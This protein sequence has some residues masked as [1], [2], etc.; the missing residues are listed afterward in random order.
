M[1]TVTPPYYFD[2]FL[3]PARRR[4]PTP[5]ERKLGLTLKDLDWLPT[6]YYATDA[7]RANSTVQGHPMRVERLLVN[8]P[9]QPAIPLAGAFMIS[10]TPDDAKAVLYTP[11]GGLE[12]F[13]SHAT[14]LKDVETRLARPAQRAEL[15]QFVS[16]AERGALPSTAPLTLSTAVILGAVMEDQEQSIL[17]GQQSNLAAMLNELRA[18]PSLREMLDTILGTMARADFP[19]LNQADTRVNTF[20]R[21]P[22]GGERQWVASEPLREVLLRFYVQQSWPVDQTH[23]FFNPAHDIRTFNRD[24]LAQ[25]QQRWNS[26]VE[27]TSASL[28]SLLKSL[29]RSYW[30]ADVTVG[31]SRRQFFAQAMRDK[32]RADLLFKHQQTIVSSDESQALRSLFLADQTARSVADKH[33]NVEKARIHAP[34][35]HYVDLAGT[36]M[37]SHT[38]A[39]L[40]TQSRG[41]QVL[42]NLNDLNATLLTMLKTAG[43]EDELLNFLSLDERNVF[44]GMDQIQI[45]GKPVV[46]DVFQEM[47]EDILAK[48]LDNLEYVLGQYRRSAGGV[49]LGALL[50]SALDVRNLLDSRLLERET[51]GR[52]S[53]HPVTRDNARPATVLAEK[54]RLHLQRLQTVEAAMAQDRNKYP[55]YAQ[56]SLPSLP[57]LLLDANRVHLGW[58]MLQGLTGEV[59]LRQLQKNLPPNALALLG[60]ALNSDGMSRLTRHGLNG[61]I[62]DAYS[63][64]LKVGANT[65]LQTVSNCFVLTER[66]GTDPV[67]SGAAVLWTPRYGYEAFA[68][69]KVLGETLAQR[70]KDPLARLAL[71]ENLPVTQRVPHQPY[72]L[73]PLQRIDGHLLENRQQSYG[74]VLRDEI[75]YLLSMRLRA[76]RFEQCMLSLIQRAPPTNLPRA[77]AIAR[78]LVHQQ[79]LPVWLGMAKPRQQILHA[80]LL[81][82]CRISA[83]D[84]RDYLHSVTPMRAQAVSSLSTLLN[85]RFPGQVVNPD[86]VMIPARI[87]LPG[88]TQSLTD[89]ALRHLPELRAEDVRPQSRTATPLPAALDGNAVVQLVRQLDLKSLYRKQLTPLLKGTAETVRERRQL[90]CRQLPW[91]LLRYAHEQ[92]LDNR[93]SAAGWSLVQQAFDMPDA[94]ARAAVSGA[95][96]IIRPLELI[97]TPG[98]ALVKA[99]GCYLIGSG[100]GPLILY[101]PYSPGH[102]LK[103]YATEAALLSEFT[104]PGALQ[105]WV[106]G[107]MQAPHQA[108]YRN[109]LGQSGDRGGSEFSLGSTPIAGNLLKQLFQDNGD[110]L[111]Q[112]LA[113]QFSKS[114][115]AQWDAVT[116]LLSQ[117]IPKSVQFLAGKLAYPLVVWR[118][119]KLFK[120]SAEDLQQ[121]RWQHAL[122]TFACGVAELA[123]LRNELDRVLPSTPAPQQDS[124][125]EHQLQAP[126]PTAQALAD[127]D[128]T[129]PERTQLQAFERHDI[130]MVDLAQIAQTGVYVDG[131]GTRHFVP[132]AGKVYPV[133]KAGEHWRLST[134]ELHGPYVQRDA[135]GAWTLDLG[136]HHPRYGQSLQGMAGRY[137]T[138]GHEREIINVEARGIRQIAALSSWKAQCINEGLN[139]ATYYAA[140]CKKNLTHFAIARD[141]NSR[142]GRFFS[143]FFGVVMLTADQVKRIERRIDE[144]LDELTNHTLVG[145]ESQ[146]FVIG[147]QIVGPRD[148]FAFVMPGDPDHKI[149]LLNRF[150]DPC[151]DMYENRLNT[152]FDISAHA[153]ATVLIHEITHIKSL[154]E[155]LAYLESMRPFHDLINL[156]MQG[157]SVMRTDLEVI[158]QTALSTLTPA[159][160][161]F[162]TWDEFKQKWEDFGSDSSTS[163]LRDKVLKTTG[164]RSI[165]AARS[166]F[167]SNDEKRIDTILAN[168]DSVT[169]LIS[170]LGRKLDAGA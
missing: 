167:M 57:N 110:M 164:G 56:K 26:V 70:L 154:T 163:L 105:D 143:E 44:V 86:N 159:T 144:V 161:L 129:A 63:L 36:L 31:Q 98:A 146:R 102:L 55:V 150:F 2:E 96:A 20:R 88:N 7:A 126:T 42:A 12:L 139:V 1:A 62:P 27:N 8:L 157:A 117:G 160:M 92:M 68:S 76:K 168:A 69:V 91:Q 136:V 71:L 138:R 90:F 142:L 21:G 40:Y 14:L 134:D 170:Q 149:Y 38:Q 169:Y 103:E 122:R 100:T 47:F 87:N 97:A 111:L 109:L 128:L 10:A 165:D 156:G 65:A 59:Q 18:L 115:Q 166:I 116:R 29:L 101:A 53:I 61:F 28:S 35:Q 81:E 114:G 137:K 82:Q 52:W 9:D 79:A 147:T 112:M 133:R 145:P 66:G 74:D 84:E 73:G 107:Q 151:L 135:Q 25:D 94:F 50:D 3:R 13:D 120:T 17:A 23:S 132:L 4:E 162:K 45:A 99:L 15:L 89:F 72:Q 140:T 60:S 37:I 41:L 131:A 124:V 153:R 5:R 16:I 46:G 54:A 123:S 158:R 95:T 39:Y 118:S 106:T 24:Q 125:L 49:D 58:G 155:D 64:A 6:L 93:L 152:P 11:Y 34:F 77:I 48:Q 130:G 104:T 113:C 75:G 32:C 121:H 67:H 19:G 51:D 22:A 85:A 30:N 78:A 148:T 83:T 108:T 33:L 43:Y 127:L 119:Y 141:L 80:E